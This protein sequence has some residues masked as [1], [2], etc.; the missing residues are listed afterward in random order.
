MIEPTMH[1]SN[2][3]RLKMKILNDGINDFSEI[4]LMLMVVTISLVIT[5]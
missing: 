2:M 3:G 5:I 1:S 4:D